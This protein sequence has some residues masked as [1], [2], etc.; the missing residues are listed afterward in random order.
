[1]QRVA[2][3]HWFDRIDETVILGALPLRSVT[4][5]ILKLNVSGIV[6]MTES[7]ETR[8]WVTT[9]KEWAERGIT[10][11]VLSTPDLIAAP[12]QSKLVTG[13]QFLLNHV[14]RRQQVYVHCKAGRT[15]SAT[16]VA[17]Y[18]M[19]RHGWSPEESVEFIRARRPH[20]KIRMKQWTALK[21]YHQ[22]N[23]S[24]RPTS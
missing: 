22:Q 24:R 16:L 21:T 1:M 12:S 3:R 17:C 20:I 2:G 8:R 15:R 23:I 7:H 18:L 5:E 4:D 19:Q 10:Q 13:V 11:L 6:S 14:E 9:E